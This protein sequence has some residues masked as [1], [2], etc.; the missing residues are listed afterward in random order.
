MKIK[1]TYSAISLMVMLA[2]FAGFGWTAM[3]VLAQSDTEETSSCLLIGTGNEAVNGEGADEASTT[4]EID[5][6]GE[7]GAQDETGDTGEMNDDSAD[8]EQ[9]PLL[10]TGS[11]TVDE[12]AFAGMSAADRCAA[13]STLAKIM[14]EAAQTAAGVEGT[15]VKVELDDENGFLVYSV[16][17][18]DGRDVKVDAGSGSILHIEAT[19]SDVASDDSTGDQADEVA[20]ANTGITAEK[21]QAIAEAKTGST[22][23]AVEYDVE[24]GI[25]LFEVELKD[26][27][28]VKVSAAD[29]TILL[30]EPRDAN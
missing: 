6:P 23:R 4:D 9:S 12:A 2:L 19:G 7:A 20:P 28:D 26:G 27:T 18:S 25:E 3:H 21:A 10:Y 22:A 24:N 14:P 29:G 8:Q 30:I 11:I 15:V 13:L 16:E 17:L 5:N 1:R